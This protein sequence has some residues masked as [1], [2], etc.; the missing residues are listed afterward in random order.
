MKFRFS[1][2]VLCFLACTA[3]SAGALTFYEFDSVE[4]LINSLVSEYN[5]ALSD[6][7]ADEVVYHISRLTTDV[8]GSVR[9][10]AEHEDRGFGL[11]NLAQ[12]LE[13]E[14]GRALAATELREA[15]ELFQAAAIATDDTRSHELS[16]R[17]AAVGIELGEFDRAIRLAAEVESQDTEPEIQE[18]ASILGLRALW[19]RDGEEDALERMRR[20]DPQSEIGL[21]QWY[22]MDGDTEEAGQ[23]LETDQHDSLIARVFSG[24]VGR[25]S[26]PSTF[27]SGRMPSGRIVGADSSSERSDEG[28]SQIADL[29]A[30]DTV[31][32]LQLGSYQRL[33]YAEAHSGNVNEAGYEST[34]ETAEDGTH[35]VLIVFEEGRSRQEAEEKLLRLRDEGFEGFIRVSLD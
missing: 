29:D 3:V 32:G 18:R 1:L 17:A 11:E 4:N 15:F 10:I 21:Y 5:E 24:E 22:L 20:L 35:K 7:T 12:R 34:V 8:S 25:P 19:F 31:A 30:G 28:S 26:L 27:L 14:A 6:E 33:E 9:L 13:I 16:L 23:R 2:S